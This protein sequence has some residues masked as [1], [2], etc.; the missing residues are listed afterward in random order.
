MAV[1]LII[2]KEFMVKTVTHK[3]LQSYFGEE[4][5]LEVSQNMTFSQMVFEML[6]GNKPTP[7]ELRLFDLVLNLSIDHGPDTPSAQET[8]KAAKE[9]ESL[10]ESV[11][12]GVEEINDRHGGAVTPLMEILYK[13]QKLEDKVSEVVGEYLREGKKM[14]GFGHRIY[15]ESDPRREL[16]FNK[17]NEYGLGKEYINVIESLHQELEKQTGK[18]LPI[19]IDGAIATVLCSFGWEPRL[20]NCVFVI[21]RVPGLCAQFLTNSSG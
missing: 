17:L 6:S 2:E 18:T 9:G 3:G 19:N 12:E 5:H 8:I 16:L 10:G 11:S 14:P 20:G 15:K 4:D 21:A 7:D 13:I 1:R